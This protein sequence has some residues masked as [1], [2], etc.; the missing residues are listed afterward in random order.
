MDKMEVDPMT[1]DLAEMPL[2]ALTAE[3]EAL[4]SPRVNAN[5][6]SSFQALTTALWTQNTP[7]VEKTIRELL[8]PML[9]DWLDVHLPQLVEQLIRKEIERLA[10]GGGR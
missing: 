3:Q 9:R 4:L 10:R 8:R 6:A 5:L 1:E 2:P 7:L